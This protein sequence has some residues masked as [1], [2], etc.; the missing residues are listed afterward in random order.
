MIN[1]RFASKKIG[2]SLQNR[3]L[4]SVIR[5]VSVVFKFSFGLLLSSNVSAHD[6]IFYIQFIY[7]LPFLISFMGLEIYNRIQLKSNINKD[8][9]A[10]IF[11]A[12]IKNQIYV[13]ALIYLLYTLIFGFLKLYALIL[14][15]MVL[16]IIIIE[17]NRYNIAVKKQFNASMIL[18]IKN[19]ISLLGLFIIG[20]L[21]LIGVFL[22]LIAANIFAALY[23]LYF[24]DLRFSRRQ[25]LPVRFYVIQIK[26]YWLVLISVCLV[27][28]FWV[29]DK[30]LLSF[31]ETEMAFKYAYTAFIA[32]GFLTLYEIL[33]G[34]FV[35]PKV[36]DNLKHKKAILDG[37][38]RELSLVCCAI[39]LLGGIVALSWAHLGF[40]IPNAKM[41]DHIV[42]IFLVCAII[43]TCLGYPV[44]A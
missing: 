32:A 19:V 17:V 35:T 10:R 31:I 4:P 15:F 24:L 8:L 6:F 18:L 30:K 11:S 22:I 43:F 40:L 23:G 25:I 34:M 41:F 26:K 37:I 12:N 38:Y 28:L 14:I 36:L 21:D 1:E 44:S 42:F 29:I 2:F 33:S 5:L 3:F 27:R 9:T 13:F 39:L 7:F 20:D 16:E